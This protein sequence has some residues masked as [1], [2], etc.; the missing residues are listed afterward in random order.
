MAINTSYLPKDVQ[1]AIAANPDLFRRSTTAAN[2][3]AS[4]L[5]L[6]MSG[7][8][9]LGIQTGLGY[10]SNLG[11]AW[12]GQG[13]VDYATKNGGQWRP[14]DA[15]EDYSN[16][17]R[18]LPGAEQAILNSAKWDD[19]TGLYV[20][21]GVAQ[22]YWIPDK[23][24][25]MDQF[26]GTYFPMI[27][28]G[29][30]GAGAA[31]FIP[32]VQGAGA[33]ATGSAAGGGIGGGMGG[34]GGTA[35]A[36]TGLGTLP[37][38][39]TWAQTAVPTLG[40]GAGQWTLPAAL[41]GVEGATT[42]AGG[43]T[44]GDGLAH[45]FD[46]IPIPYEG[47]TTTVPEGAYDSP[48]GNG[49]G[50]NPTNYT[51]DPSMWDK[52]T[53]ILKPNPASTAAQAATQG[54]GDSTGASGYL[55]KIATN[56]ANN[57]RDVLG[58][59]AGLY[60]LYQNN[61]TSQDLGG[62]AS[63]LA[64]KSD[65]FGSQRSQYQTRLKESYDNPMSI[66]NSPEYQGLADMYR[67]KIEAKDAAAGRRSQYSA[68]ELEMQSNFLNYLQGY[69]KDLASLAGA[70]ISPNTSS[71]ANASMAS[72]Q[73]GNNMEDVIGILSYLFPNSSKVSRDGSSSSTK[74]VDV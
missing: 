74:G 34:L 64:E 67:K 22:K 66:Y 30:I 47:L 14:Y 43:L 18:W 27:A 12:N 63:D 69:R 71:S 15:A 11:D 40:A 72:I 73:S 1:A 58:I 70:G 16:T 44:L 9:N 49:E 38:A 13:L 57:P 35:A 6:D 68:R 29:A 41:S 31:G 10:T 60:G 3:R 36:K 8:S 32:G 42:V 45:A 46:N 54:T 24:N 56:L 37:T 5:G 48:L 19:K 53:N 33:A 28:A 20:D 61:Q 2:N 52:I 26:M 51:K 21:D 59:I 65:P 23:G 55:D 50:W 62:L 4:G 25:F 39:G 17:K 7:G